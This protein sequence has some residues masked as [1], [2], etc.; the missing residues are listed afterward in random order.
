MDRQQQVADFLAEYDLEADPAYRILD[1]VSEV[2]EVAKDAS[3]STDYGSAP[4]ELDVNADEVGD[5]LFAVLALADS[6]D[7][8]AG[9]AL[10]EA[11]AKYEERL[12]DTGSAG[13]GE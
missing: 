9:E 4:G 7:V 3:V 6:L 5:V 12:A 10:D 1:L 8:D 2:G 13:S 11:L